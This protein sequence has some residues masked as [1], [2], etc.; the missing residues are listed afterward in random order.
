MYSWVLRPWPTHTSTR[1]GSSDTEVTEF[2]VI[3]FTYRSSLNAVSKVTPV[4]NLRIAFLRS[5]PE[6]NTGPR[7]RWLGAITIASRRAA[8]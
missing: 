6:T 2:A 4:V 7:F 5:S 3:A 1:G 8:A